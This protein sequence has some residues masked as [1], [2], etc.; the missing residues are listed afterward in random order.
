[1]PGLASVFVM[2][3]VERFV[4]FLKTVRGVS[5]CNAKIC[6]GVAR[7]H[8]A[9][10]AVS[11]RCIRIPGSLMSIFASLFAKAHVVTFG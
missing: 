9:E 8:P 10:T 7:P 5:G 2:P 4:I 6:G 11:V 3:V 1:L